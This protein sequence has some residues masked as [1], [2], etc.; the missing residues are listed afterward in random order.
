MFIIFDLLYVFCFNYLY[1]RNNCLDIIENNEIIFVR[2][3]IF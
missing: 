1:V 2:M 3:L